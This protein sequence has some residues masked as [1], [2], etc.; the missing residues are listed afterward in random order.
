MLLQPEAVLDHEQG[1]RWREIEGKAVVL[2]PDGDTVHQLNETGAR[3]W[4]EFDGRRPIEVIAEVVADDYRTDCDRVLA[5]LLD[6]GAR[7]LDAG[8]VCRV[9]D[10]REA[11]V[12]KLDETAGRRAG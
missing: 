7:L 12:E 5:D 11:S 2:A 6:L 3:F 9:A 1:V 8:L 10:V 4:R